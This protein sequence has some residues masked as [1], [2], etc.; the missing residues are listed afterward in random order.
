M[1]TIICRTLR[2]NPVPGGRSGFTLA[3][4]LC[5]TVIVGLGAAAILVSAASGSRANNIGRKLTEAVFLAQELREWTY[6]LPFSDPDTADQGNPPG[7]D[8]MN[9]QTFVDDLDDLMG[10]TYSPPRDGQG[11]AVDDLTVWSQLI[12]LTWR[13]PADLDTI[14]ANGASDVIYVEVTISYQGS[15]ALK[16]GWLVTR[17][18]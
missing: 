6:Q 3:E 18:G 15:E 16:T 5:A 11:I 12:D 9:P 7:S 10:V 8:G 17:K 13:D 1:R 2:T 4:A 14:V